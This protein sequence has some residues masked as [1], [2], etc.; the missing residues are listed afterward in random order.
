MIQRYVIDLTPEGTPMCVTLTTGYEDYI[1]K[2]VHLKLQIRRAVK[3]LYEHLNLFYRFERADLY[4]IKWYSRYDL[5]YSVFLDGK[6][7]GDFETKCPCVID[8]IQS[9]RSIF[10]N[11]YELFVGKSLRKSR[12]TLK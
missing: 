10:A 6:H 7:V 3:K 5:G 9:L 8:D 11:E 12:R 4:L 2:A 1:M